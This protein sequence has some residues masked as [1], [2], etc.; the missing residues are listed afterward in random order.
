MPPR[1]ALHAAAGLGRCHLPKILLIASGF[2]ETSYED[3][4]SG[5]GWRASQR[6]KCCKGLYVKQLESIAQIIPSKTR[7]LESEPDKFERQ[8]G[9]Q[10]YTYMLVLSP[11]TT[12][13]A[14]IQRSF[15][16]NMPTRSKSEQAS[17]CENTMQACENSSISM[18]SS[19]ETLD[20]AQSNQTVPVQR[21]FVLGDD[22]GL[23]PQE[24]LELNALGCSLVSLGPGMLL[25]SQCITIINHYLDVGIQSF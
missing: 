8:N 20:S 2:V 7:G 24:I 15:C 16:P 5:D 4:S 23:L 6:S 21:N 3:P 17:N 1:P 10:Q 9:F 22:V 18:M 13:P 19:I 12:A 14:E 25:T 11:K